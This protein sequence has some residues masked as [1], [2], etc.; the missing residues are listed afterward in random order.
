MPID[1]EL[2]KILC[3]PETHQALRLAE[4]ELIAQLNRQAAA[5]TLENHSGETVGEPLEAGLLREDRQF[6]YPI[7]KGIPVLLI[8][9]AIA[10]AV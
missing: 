8:G 2:L 9:E 10:V 1:S 3:C 6:L 7:R 5:G 4:P